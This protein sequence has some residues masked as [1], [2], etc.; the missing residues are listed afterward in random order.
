MSRS[1]QGSI[2]SGRAVRSL[3]CLAILWPTMVLAPRGAV[4]AASNNVGVVVVFGEGNVHQS[5]IAFAEN[6]LTS[7]DLLKRDANLQVLSSPATS[8][9]GERVCKINDVG[10]TSPG[11]DCWC[12][13]DPLQSCK[14]WTYWRWIGNTWVFV[15]PTTLSWMIGNG[16]MEAWVWGSGDADRPPNVD[17]LQ[18]CSSAET[19]PTDTSVPATATA[20]TQ[21]SATQTPTHTA[22]PSAT[23]TPSSTAQPTASLT[24]TPHPTGTH[25]PVPPTGTLTGDSPYPGTSS[26]SA[27]SQTPLPSA[28]AETSQTP[29]PTGTTTPTAPA[30]PSPTDSGSA[31]PALPSE[32]PA[33]SATPGLAGTSAPSTAVPPEGSPTAPPAGEATTSTLDP[34]ASTTAPQEEPQGVE[35]A[36][37]TPTP[38]QVAMMIYTGVAEH[39]GTPVPGA[40]QASARSPSGFYYALSIVALLVLVYAFLLRRQRQ[41]RR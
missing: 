17:Y 18:I 3:L 9:G 11:E 25:T 41:R 35:V 8:G 31:Y 29:L 39:M 20:T 10:C 28:T 36:A 12:Q 22:Q 24:Q 21:G 15:G 13:C 16:D 14:R 34:S 26:T 23:W 6:G 30:T 38:D 19:T 5:C 37:T 40:E 4:G 27:P 33:A 1:R 7:I 32:T 2:L